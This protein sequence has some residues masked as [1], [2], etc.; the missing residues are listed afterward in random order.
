MVRFR[1]QWYYVGK[2]LVMLY[3]VCLREGTMVGTK[4]TSIDHWVCVRANDSVMA[5]RKARNKIAWQMK[6]GDSNNRNSEPI[7]VFSTMSVSTIAYYI[8]LEDLEIGK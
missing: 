4:M 6:N 7:F 8:D 5:K 2:G 1:N 3:R